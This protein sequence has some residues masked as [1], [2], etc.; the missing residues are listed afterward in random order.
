[1]EVGDAKLWDYF[2]NE[3]G[4]KVYIYS[5]VGK[6]TANPI[7]VYNLLLGEWDHDYFVEGMLAH[8]KCPFLYSYGEGGQL[9]YENTF[10]YMLDGKD[11]EQ[12][13]IRELRNVTN[14]FMIKELEPETSYIDSMYLLAEL[15]SG[16]KVKLQVVDNPAL[17]KNDGK[18][19]ITNK[20]DSVGIEFE[21]LPKW[22]VKTYIMA[23]GYY[24]YH[25]L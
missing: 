2:L 15:K 20:G 24:I 11:K 16:K 8:N 18:Y 1:M 6:I 7:T 13:Q 23:K 5:I 19:L 12:T 10:I 4:E 17:Q 25:Q 21:S 9:V 14:K 3:S 22:T